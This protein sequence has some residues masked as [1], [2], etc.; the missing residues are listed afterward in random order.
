M[1]LVQ[2]AL[3]GFKRYRSRRRNFTVIIIGSYF[4]ICLFMLF[5]RT[6]I[7]NIDQFWVADYVGGDLIVSKTNKT[8]DFTRPVPPEQFF[9]FS[10]FLSRNPTYR[11]RVSPCLRIGALIERQIYGQSSYCIVNGIDLQNQQGF[12]RQLQLF[13]GRMFN[14]NRNEVVL[15]KQMA[16]NLSITLGDSLIIYVITKD[17]YLNFDLLQVVGLLDISLPAQ[18]FFSQTM[19]YMPLAKLQELMTVDQDQVSEAV[20]FKKPGLLGRPLRG[21]YKLI[22]GVTSFS[23]IRSLFFAFR[24]L[25]AVI[26]FLIFVMAFCAIYHNVGLMN[27]EREKE[28]GVYLTSGAK[29]AW[30]RWLMNYELLIYTVY[31][32]LWGGLL[33]LLVVTGVNSLGIY[34]DD[35]PMKLLMACSHFSI[36]N[37][38]G[39]YLLAF[40]I[41]LF[42]MITGSLRPVWRATENTRIIEL[43]Q[44]SR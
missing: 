31:C 1:A 27:V 21:N 7:R 41:V 5:F 28:I 30:I 6:V 38:P 35:I 9:R 12:V 14:S 39:I 2:I 29:P 44:K 10:Q 33:T 43:L 19:V 8:Y 17:G 23:L 37:H 25:E 15:P 16:E 20:V 42:L 34:P 11:N 32:S 22:K 24:F 13:E 3:A 18:T 4:L 40:L 26:L 36:G